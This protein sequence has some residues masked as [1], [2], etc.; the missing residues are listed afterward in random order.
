[1]SNLESVNSVLDRVLSPPPAV[2][3]LQF[4]LNWQEPPSMPASVRAMHTAAQS[5]LS[6]MAAGVTEGRWLSFIGQSGCGKTHLARAIRAAAR[7]RLFLRAQFWSVASIADKLRA[8]EYDFLDWLAS[9]DFLALDDL[10]AE[11]STDFSRAKLTHL[12]DRRE[13][14]WTVITSNLSLREIGD[15]MD[16]RVSSRINRNGR[17]IDVKEPW[18]YC[19]AINK[20][21][22]T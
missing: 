11:Y 20:H 7:D 9:L 13:H 6:H 1:M 4:N 8:G 5:Y 12:M 16:C 3:A 21:N 17:V 22:N 15:A 19:L 14:K 2:P 10:G 18:D